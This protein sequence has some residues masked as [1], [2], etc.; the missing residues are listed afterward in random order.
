M[1]IYQQI[2]AAIIVIF[3]L[4]MADCEYDG[5]TA[6]WKL[7]EEE[8]DSP[9]ITE[10]VPSVAVAGVNYLTINGE[11]FTDNL[12]NVNVYING[13]K[14]EIVDFSNS[15]IK[16]RRPDRSGDSLSIKVSVYGAVNLG[17]WEPYTITSVYEPYGQ[18]LSG[19]TLGCLAIDKDENV[20]VVEHTATLEVYK[21]APTGEKTQIGNANGTI[22]GAAIDPNGQIYLF[23]NL[24]DIYVV[25]S[26]TVHIYATVSKRVN[27]GVFDSHGTLYASG[28]SADINIILPDLSIKQAGLYARDEIFCLRVF[29]NFLYALINLRSSDELH[30]E[31]A[32]WRH[33]ILDGQG[34]LGDAELVFDWASAGEAYAESTPATF[35]I[36]SEG[37]IYI[38]SDNVAPILYYDPST[39]NID[40][41]YKG[42]I[43]SG[44]TKLL[45]GNGNY[46]YM[47]YSGGTTQYNL[48]RI[49]MGRPQDRDF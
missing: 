31:M 27:T 48:F 38:G 36:D 26:D 5:P 2:L 16:I 10:V 4:V 19:I 17:R 29:D 40:E 3:I 14:A 45:W 39:G 20:Y 33:Q 18:F 43:P 37:G 41:I 30:P 23:R 24:Y 7:V 46:L 12:D 9:T 8:T 13:Y 11:N 47:V 21:I 32:I 28:R 6:Q 49:D 42:I 25:E 1:K 35:T 22:Q 44:A 15:S 34:N